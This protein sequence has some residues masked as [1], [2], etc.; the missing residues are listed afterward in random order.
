MN[1]NTD[2]GKALLRRPLKGLQSGLQRGKQLLQQIEQ[3]IEKR[4][5]KRLSPFIV[6]A[7]THKKKAAYFYV[8]LR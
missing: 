7:F 3:R 4:I 5:E 1:Q 2:L 8:Q 6:G